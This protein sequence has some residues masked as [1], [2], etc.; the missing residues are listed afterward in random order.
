MLY[1]V[2]QITTHVLTWIITSKYS[3]TKVNLLNS[4]ML[5]ILRYS[6]MDMVPSK[7]PL[8]LENR[9]GKMASSTVRLA[10]AVRPAEVHIKRCTAEPR[11]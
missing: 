11:R 5:R 3:R 2:A 6:L 4:C 1:W 9:Y 10:T 7:C 8:P